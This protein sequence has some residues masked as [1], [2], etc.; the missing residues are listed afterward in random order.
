MRWTLGNEKCVQRIGKD[1][2]CDLLW[3]NMEQV[4]CDMQLILGVEQ[5]SSGGCLWSVKITYIDILS[6]C[7]GHVI[8]RSYK[9]PIFKVLSS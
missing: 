9:K 5:I 7:Q 2:I 3:H 4:A 1:Y 6:I 8:V